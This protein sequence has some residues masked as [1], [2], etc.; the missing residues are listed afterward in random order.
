MLLPD[1]WTISLSS[2][3]SVDMYSILLK[4]SQNELLHQR[5]VQSLS[6]E[7]FVFAKVRR[8]KF[9]AITCQHLMDEEATAAKFPELFDSVCFKPHKFKA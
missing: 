3:Q 2:L 1:S 6:K 7:L 4:V 5:L 8:C 9:D